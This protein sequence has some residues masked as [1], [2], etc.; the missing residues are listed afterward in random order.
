MPNVREVAEATPTVQ[1]WY[2]QIQAFY[3]DPDVR[4]AARNEP[5]ADPE[6]M[7]WAAVNPVSQNPMFQ[8]E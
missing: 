7:E 4:I 6:G 3:S 5:N 2:S 1:D 8:R